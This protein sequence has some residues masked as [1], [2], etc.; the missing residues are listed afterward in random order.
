MLPESRLCGRE[1]E[2][3]RRLLKA[4]TTL[5]R[6]EAVMKNRMRALL[7]AEGTGDKKASLKS[8]RGR[9]K[10]LNTLKER[11]NGLAAQ[12]LF[13]TTGRLQADVNGIEDEIRRLAAGGP[14][15]G[16]A[17]DDSRMR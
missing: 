14:G 1:S 3:M 10:V 4:R 12:P 7:T 15:G 8:K 2:Q 11:G 13:D 17:D 9:R 6:T 5:V 16:T